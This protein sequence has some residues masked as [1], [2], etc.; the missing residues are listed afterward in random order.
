M[1]ARLR[2]RPKPAIRDLI[3]DDARVIA[4]EGFQPYAMS[5]P[6][7]RGRYYRLNDEIVKQFPMYFAIVVP[8]SEV[9]GEI[10]RGG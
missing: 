8:V 5:Q 1:A 6:V 4:T 3:D 2:E 10:E 7:E 9:I